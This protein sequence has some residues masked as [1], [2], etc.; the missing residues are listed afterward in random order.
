MTT[1]MEQNLGGDPALVQI[2]K[3]WKTRALDWVFAQGSIAI[4][5]I[6]WLGW[7]IYDG[8]QKDKAW[9]DAAAVRKSW[10]EQLWTK[11]DSRLIDMSSAYERSLE[12]VISAYERK[13]ERDEIR[14][15]K[16]VDRIKGAN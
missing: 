2:A 9:M 5:L 13:T 6:A 10:E 1:T 12:K 15:D 14:F 8:I 4:V 3:D 7:T 11:I 16:I